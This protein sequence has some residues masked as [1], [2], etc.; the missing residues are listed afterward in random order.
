MSN[1]VKNI[2]RFCLFVL[3]QVFI[4]DKVPPL[5]QMATPYIYFLFVLWLPFKIGR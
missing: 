4:L 5:H 3:A 2:I 1:L